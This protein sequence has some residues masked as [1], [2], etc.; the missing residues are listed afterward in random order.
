MLNWPFQG[1]P[2]PPF[3]PPAVQSYLEASYFCDDWCFFFLAAYCW[4]SVMMGF[5]SLTSYINSR[6]QDNQAAW[7]WEILYSPFQGFPR[8]PFKLPAV[9][10]YLE[11]NGGV[12]LLWWLV[13]FF[14]LAAY[15][16]YSVMMGF[17]SLT[18]YINSRVQDNQAAWSWE[19]F[20]WPFQGFPRP[21]LKPPASSNLFRGQTVGG[22]GSRLGLWIGSKVLWGTY[23]YWFTLRNQNRA[24]L[25]IM[26]FCLKIHFTSRCYTI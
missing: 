4:Y 14:V 9:Q 24:A 6:V 22:G 17:P 18:S 11:A 1:L 10:S 15:C 8:P 26:K 2:R 7:S 12:L 16:C 25:K 3:K 19:I 23:C 13:F 21:L 5:P 20:Y